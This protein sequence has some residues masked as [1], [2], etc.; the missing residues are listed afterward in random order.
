MPIA[1]NEVETQVEVEPSGSEGRRAASPAEALA[2]WEELAR[3][4]KQLAE[5]VSAWCFDD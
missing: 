4:E 1:I 3:R 5:R 2:R